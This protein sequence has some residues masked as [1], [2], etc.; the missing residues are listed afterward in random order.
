MAAPDVISD[1]YRSVLALEAELVTLK[2]RFHCLPAS[3]LVTEMSTQLQ[4]RITQCYESISALNKKYG[5]AC[6]LPSSITE[7]I[8]QLNN[9][10]YNLLYMN[11]QLDRATLS[12]LQQLANVTKR[13]Y[14]NQPTLTSADKASYLIFLSNLND[15]IELA[16]SRSKLLKQFSPGIDASLGDT[17]RTGHI[18]P[19]HVLA[20]AVKNNQTLRERGFEQYSAMSK[21]NMSARLNTLHLVFDKLCAQFLSDKDLSQYDDDAEEE[22][23]KVMYTDESE[24]INKT[25]IDY[26]RGGVTFYTDTVTPSL[27]GVFVFI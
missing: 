17:P 15:A 4:A 11:Y 16:A 23:P 3:I 10:P 12:Q 22:I 20:Q 7:L 25:Q 27:S 8:T 26:T 9:T 19:A 5:K 21:R 2:S 1:V 18:L 13:K 14:L 24:P 6:D